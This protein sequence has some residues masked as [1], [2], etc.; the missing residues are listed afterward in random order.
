VSVTLSYHYKG[1]E[2]VKRL[3]ILGIVLAA[4]TLALVLPAQAAMVQNEKIPVDDVLWIP[5]ANGGAG[6]DVHFTGS[7]HVTTSMTLA[8]QD[9]GH[10]A[11]HTNYQGM[12]GIGLTTG[13]MYQ[14]TTVANVV[15]NTEVFISLEETIV[16]NVRITAL[17]HGNNYFL[18]MVYHITEK[19]PT[20]IIVQFYRMTE[21]CK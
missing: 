16:E 5:C 12:Q 6:E 10:L 17:G 19:A 11:M 18:Q 7:V 9:R 20:G 13:V 3:A 1:G 8:D 15:L 21:E 14:F 4:L 2:K